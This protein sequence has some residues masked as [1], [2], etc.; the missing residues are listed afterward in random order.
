MKDYKVKIVMNKITLT[1]ELD[2]N[3]KVSFEDL[4]LMVAYVTKKGITITNPEALP[5]A[6]QKQL[7][8]FNK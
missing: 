1:S 3:S 8:P 4:N 7:P 2:P 6:F 5:L